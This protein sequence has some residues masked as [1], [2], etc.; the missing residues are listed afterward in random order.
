MHLVYY[1][2]RKMYEQEIGIRF[3]VKLEIFF[4]SNLTE[5]GVLF[6]G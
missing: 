3:S 6:G 5:S 2:G 1:V 4:S